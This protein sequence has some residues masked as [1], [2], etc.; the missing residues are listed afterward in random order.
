MALAA[1]AG[2]LGG[3]KL[4]AVSK[5][6]GGTRADLW[7]VTDGKRK[8]VVKSYRDPES[9]SWRREAAGLA[10]A[11]GTGCPE[12][13]ALVSD[14]AVVVMTDLGTGP[15]LADLLLGRDAATATDGLQAWGR[16]LANLHS[17]T[18]HRTNVFTAHLG[19]DLPVS[20]IASEVDVLPQTLSAL[21]TDHDLPVAENLTG[22]LGEVQEP[23]NRAERHVVTPGDTCPDNNLIVGD[24]V[25]LLDF[26]FAEVRHPAWDLAYLRVPWPTCWCAW[27]IPPE[28]GDAALATYRK[29]AA[30][31]LPWVAEPGFES[32]LIAA[33]LLWSLVSSSMY[34]PGALDP[35]AD[36]EAAAK[37]PG[38]RTMVLS[39]LALA[40]RLEG[41]PALT[42]YA[43]QLAA[44][45]SRR[46]GPHPLA[47]APAF[48]F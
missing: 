46:W 6:L 2:G 33:T 25:R 45:L 26:E 19:D 48:A 16:A 10:A 43:G 41:P 23:L 42:A 11:H 7:R 17:Q 28:P 39:R 5:R 29:S 44:E 34:L 37:R 20:V 13:I 38:R 1:A 8:L 36:S 4:R 27:Q 32:D 47:A 9:N 35:E 3:T 18:I 14:P 24:T 12:L 21:A 31:L 22:L 40:S 15:C 30:E